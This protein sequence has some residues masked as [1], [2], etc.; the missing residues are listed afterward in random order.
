MKNSAKSLIASLVAFAAISTTATASTL[1][2]DG[3]TSSAGLTLSS[4]A[5]D[6]WSQL[7]N[8][9]Y[10]TGLD[11]IGLQNLALATGDAYV[12]VGA[13]DAQG[14]IITGATGLAS[15]VLSQT[16]IN[17]AT[18]YS[19]SNLSWYNNAY[20]FGYTPTGHINQVSADTDGTNFAGGTADDGL[21]ALRLS[22]HQN[23]GGWRAGV[24]SDGSA[25]IWLNGSTDYYKIVLTGNGGSNVPDSTSS[26]ML[27]GACFAMLA[28][29]RRLRKA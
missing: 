20:S 11:N 25:N 15:E 28:G 8:V 1:Y 26:L 14:N 24:L 10:G 4:L 21:N 17:V 29:V 12:F 19:S 16:G 27:V 18:F 2:V 23:G 22:W 6:G 13:A 3:V 9:T 5:S 7:V